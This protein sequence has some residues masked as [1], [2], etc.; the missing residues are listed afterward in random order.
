MSAFQGAFPF[1]WADGSAQQAVGAHSAALHQTG[2]GVAGGPAH[3]AMHDTDPEA[4][5]RKRGR[6]TT[7]QASLAS[8]RLQVKRDRER[9]RR[10]VMAQRFI[11]LS[12]QLDA[13]DIEAGRDAVA[14]LARD[15]EA[16]KRRGEHTEVLLRALQ[17]IASLSQANR[18]LRQ[19]AG[20]EG[21][22]LPADPARTNA[23]PIANANA[24]PVRSAAPPR[25]TVVPPTVAAMQPTK[26][27][28]Q[29]MMMQPYF[30]PGSVG[31]YMQMR[32]IPP[33]QAGRP[34]TMMAPAPHPLM[35]MGQMGQ[36]GLMG[37]M[38][39]MGQ[40]MAQ[41]RL[42]GGAPVAKPP[43]ALPIPAAQ[44]LAGAPPVRAAQQQ[45]QLPP[46]APYYGGPTA[47]PRVGMYEVPG[48]RPPPPGRGPPAGPPGLVGSPFARRSSPAPGAGRGGGAASA[49]AASPFESDYAP[50]A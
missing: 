29:M 23:T 46:N 32:M 13:L 16:E 24:P 31:S 7:S 44:P 27:Q 8:E 36:M 1:E 25:S 21:M 2:N 37:Q 17:A 9:N 45:V 30:V 6:K 41:H 48:P 38:G 11:Q 39:Q 14:E 50:A 40:A 12:A 10:Q 15:P 3:D 4:P 18:E 20:I 33:M 19:S 42:Q 28:P 35:Q 43:P 26:L 49:S 47:P 5:Q 34:P 22:R